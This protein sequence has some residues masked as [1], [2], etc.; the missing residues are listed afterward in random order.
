MFRQWETNVQ[1]PQSKFEAQIFSVNS[2]V[3]QAESERESEFTMMKEVI[4]KLVIA[5]E[6][7]ASHD[8]VLQQSAVDEAKNQSAAGS[9]LLEDESQMTGSQSERRR[10][11]RTVMMK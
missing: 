1:N 4:Q 10:E 8:M 11:R 5:L 3:Q 6:D 2:K 9:Q 7:K